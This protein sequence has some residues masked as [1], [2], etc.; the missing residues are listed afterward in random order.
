MQSYRSLYPNH[1]HQLGVTV[2]KHYWVTNSGIIKHQQKPMTTKLSNIAKS[3]KNHL[4]HFTI[5]DH[6]SAVVYAEVAAS[7]DMIG[8]PEFLFRAWSQKQNFAFCGIPE[9]LMLPKT[10]D[11]AYPTIASAVSQLGIKIFEPKNGFQAGIKDVETIEQY[12]QMYNGQVFSDN[13]NNLNQ[14]YA[15]LA[16]SKHRTGKQSKIDLWQ[17]NTS[18]AEVEVPSQSWLKSAIN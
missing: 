18:L 4:V 7:K 5:R 12:F 15:I 3:N 2:S 6:C 9:L 8:L 1:V 11:K 17:S 14:I 13:Q 16:N 10:V